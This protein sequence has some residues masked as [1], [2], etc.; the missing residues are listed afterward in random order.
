MV[1][2]LYGTSEAGSSTSIVVLVLAEK[3]IPFE[4]IVVDLGAMEQKTPEFLAMHPF[5]QVPVIV[6]SV[7][8]TMDNGFILYESRAI[9]RYLAEKYADQGTQLLPKTLE[10]RALLA[11]FNPVLVR[12]G[13]EVLR[14]RRRNPPDQAEVMAGL[15]AK[16]DV[17][18][19][20]LGKHNF[21]A[22][23][24]FTLADLFHLSYV[25]WIELSGIDVMTSH[26]PNVKRWWTELV[27]RPAWVKLVAEGIKG[28]TN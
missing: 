17:Y 18:E 12:A 19:E 27:S 2:K 6:S 26:G 7:W 5:G 25:V 4:H 13:K 28:T 3:Q 16:L 22:G 10:G 11:N 23:D 20:I 21:L 14:Q 8:M 24:E 9:C 15:E 1:L